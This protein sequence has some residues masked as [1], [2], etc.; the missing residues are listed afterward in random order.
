MFNREILHYKLNTMLKEVDTLCRE[1]DI[2]SFL[3]EDALVSVVRGKAL[4]RSRKIFSIAIYE[5]DI[6]KF[7]NAVEILDKRAV[8]SFHNNKKFPGFNMKYVDTDTT[9]YDVSNTDNVLM[10]NCIGI[11]IAILYDERKT[12]SIMSKVHRKA[13]L[14]WAKA[15]MKNIRSTKQKIFLMVYNILGLNKF[16]Y[17][18]AM[19]SNDSKYVELFLLNGKRVKCKKSYFG[20]GTYM[21]FQ[22]NDFMVPEETVEIACVTNNGSLLLKKDNISSIK[23]SDVISLTYPGEEFMKNINRQGI[24]LRKCAKKYNNY[25][26]WRKEKFS[27]VWKKRIKFYGYY[28]LTK[29]RFRY[30]FELCGDKKPELM[31]LYKQEDFSALSFELSK[32]VKDL[33]TY[34]Q[35]N[36]GLF[37]D[38]DIYL[39]AVAVILYRIYKRDSVQGSENEEIESIRRNVDKIYWQHFQPMD[40]F[41][42]DFPVDK[43]SMEAIREEIR[44]EVDALIIDMKTKAQVE[45]EE[46]DIQE[47]IEESIDS[48]L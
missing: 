20:N 23:Q 30:Y 33:K 24:K 34:T 26:S 19:D 32:Y 2:P 4:P 17:Y 16:H 25:V 47:L 8:E 12:E 9:Y 27:P 43:K 29:D 45:E 1:N 18:N 22:G 42:N 21:N 48:E 28:Y 15:I 3:I 31:E 38:K 36:Q 46:T 7:I 35:K 39:M 40:M 6:E 5:K 14:I 11:N 10:H 37:F 13:E 44:G 41:I